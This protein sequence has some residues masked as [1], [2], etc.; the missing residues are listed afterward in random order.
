MG[1]EA[2]RGV[3]SHACPLIFGDKILSPSWSFAP[4]PRLIQGQYPQGG[5]FRANTHRACRREKYCPP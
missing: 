1:T 5:D 3:L 2:G 4:Q